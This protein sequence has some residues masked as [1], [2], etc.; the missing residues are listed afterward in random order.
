MSNLYNPEIEEAVIAC[1]LKDGTIF[2]YLN[3]ICEYGDFYWKP[4]SWVWKSFASLYERGLAI[5]F[6]TLRDELQ[7]VGWFD[8]FVSATGGLRGIE[9]LE[10]IKSLDVVFDNSE[11]YALKVK[12]DSGKRQIKEKIAKANEQLGDGSSSVEILTY[13]ENEMGRIS[14]FTGAKS[15]LI[16]HTEDVL[17][18]AMESTESAS[19]GN[20]KY[21]ETGI[22]ALDSK[23]GG[24]FNGQLITV[25]GRQ[26]EGKSSLLLTLAMNISCENR[27]KKKVGIFSLEMSNEEYMQRMISFH[28]GISSLDL[29]R[30]KIK[31]EDDKAYRDAIEVIKKAEIMMDDTPHLS[32]PL[33]RTKLRKMKESGV[34]IVFID[35]LDLLDY[36]SP[37]DAEYVRVNRLSY[38][39]KKLAREID[40]PIVDAQQ[41]SRS[42][43]N[44][45][46]GKDSDPKASD[47]SQA[48]ESAPNLIIMIRHKKEQN[49]IKS[50]SLYIV[51][52]R[53]GAT[54]RVDVKF[55]GA[56]TKFTDVEPGE[57]SPAGFGD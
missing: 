46:R 53:D 33:L 17:K 49:V 24:F 29:K 38:K 50:S 11:T 37:V 35:Q 40:L 55:I 9:A 42:I 15:N 14:A 6:L 54:G 30:G 19:K 57:M 43:E 34:Q 5:D 18:L 23:I 4:Y 28:S 31:P 48:G 21:I 20:R 7:R 12:D 39:L 3:D 45:S 1:V 52:N 44:I 36:G 47:L 2:Q 56:R 41:M 22:K 13:L 51:K 10:K 25:A 16:A 32:I 27:W 26:G 8:D